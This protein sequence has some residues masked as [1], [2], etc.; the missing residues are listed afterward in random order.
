[1]RFGD[2]RPAVAH[3]LPLLRGQVRQGVGLDAAAAIFIAT[4]SDSQHIPL[5]ALSA[6]YGLTVAE[7]RVLSSI[8]QGLNRGQTALAL[9]VADSTVKTHLGRI[10]AKT[11]TSTQR[12]L[13]RLISSLSAQGS[14][15]EERS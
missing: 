3:V 4:P 9:E 13:V 7:G 14:P 15:L 2:G 6:L 1:M 10:F 11:G 12:D 5:E 8:A